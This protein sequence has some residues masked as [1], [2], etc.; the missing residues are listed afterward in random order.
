MIFRAF[1]IWLL[2]AAAE[3]VHGILRVRFLNRRVGDHRARQ[4]AVF[5]GSTIVLMIA[6]LSVPWIG[7]V[8][9]PELL[10]VGAL[11]LVLML[12]F[13]V[14]VGRR[15]MRFSWNRIAADFDPRRGNLLGFGMLIL[16]AAPWLVKHW[17]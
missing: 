12:G 8:N 7:A 4:I 16:F 3:T 13:D 1:L 5:S 14:A 6:W 11:W 15:V 17:F 10:T 9:T 2:V